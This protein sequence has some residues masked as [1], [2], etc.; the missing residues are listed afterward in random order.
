MRSWGQ[1]SLLSYRVR[2]GLGRRKERCLQRCRQDTPAASGAAGWRS[3]NTRG[4]CRERACR[5]RTRR[6]A[7][8][9]R[10]GAPGGGAGAQLPEVAEVGP[11]RPDKVG[12]KG[13][14]SQA[15]LEVEKPEAT[16]GMLRGVAGVRVQEKVPTSGW[17]TVV[18]Q[19]ADG[20]GTRRGRCSP[21]RGEGVKGEDAYL[22]GR[23]RPELAWGFPP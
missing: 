11:R 9:S 6:A 12:A 7:P 23:W 18:R 2:V 4:P 20:T 13:A 3:A 15:S 5:R 10:G 21:E 17:G 22:D 19:E 14:R 1:H 16:V 8:P